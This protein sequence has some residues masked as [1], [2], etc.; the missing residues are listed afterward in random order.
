LI[1]KRDLKDKHID[2]KKIRQKVGL[3]FQFPELQLFE[4]TVFDDIA[5]GPRNLG[6]PDQEITKRVRE[7]MAELGL[8]FQTFAPR[9]PFSLS[10]GEQRKVAIAGILALNPEV[11]ILDEPTAGLDNQGVEQI[12]NV[13]SKLNKDGTTI[14]L[15]SHNLDL[16]A[17]LTRKIL[18]LDKGKL[19]CFCGKK[20]FFEKPELLCSVG[21][22]PP[23]LSEF[24]FRLSRM[25]IKMSP[26]LFALDQFITQL[27][28]ILRSFL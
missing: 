18:L 4:D 8:D 17:Q 21:L 20:E 10:G 15:I 7:C 16:A 19:I 24:A 3:V 1:D 9:S 2:L 5:F 14:V 13:L 22:R 12:K 26:S 11:L 27:S 28:S 6:L 23:E 25:G